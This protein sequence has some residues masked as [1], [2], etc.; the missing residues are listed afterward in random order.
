M[1]VTSVN[2][3]VCVCVCVPQ[4]A[5]PRDPSVSEVRCVGAALATGSLGYAGLN[6]KYRALTTSLGVGILVINNY[7]FT[8]A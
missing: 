1:I 8:Q 6:K 2:A 3:Y 4:I 7:S 5:R